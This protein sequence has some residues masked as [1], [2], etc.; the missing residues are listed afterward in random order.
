[1][2]PNFVYFFVLESQ[3]T[4]KNPQKD[5]K[6]T[7]P[8]K[9]KMAQRRPNEWPTKRPRNEAKTTSKRPGNDA[10]RYQNDAKWTQR[11]PPE[12]SQMVQNH[13]KIPRFDPFWPY[14][15]SFWPVFFCSKNAPKTAETMK[16]DVKTTQ[17]SFS[18]NC[19]KTPFW[20]V[21]TVFLW[22]FGGVLR[23]PIQKLAL[24]LSGVD[25]GMESS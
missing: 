7:P 2:L 19:N 25:F 14:F 12:T 23:L 22:I 11:W 6:S 8:E 16:K 24:S 5:R 18:S 1:M 3:Y 20:G 21:F 4:S 10:K 17:N 15:G 9:R 13:P